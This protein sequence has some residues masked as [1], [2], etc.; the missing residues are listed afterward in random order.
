MSISEITANELDVE[1]FI[2]DKAAGISE[3]V[4]N[5]TAIN[6]LSGGVDSS[7]VTLLGHMALDKKTENL[8]YR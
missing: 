1:K 5:D 7:T 3:A 8:F 4:G 6:A 2:K